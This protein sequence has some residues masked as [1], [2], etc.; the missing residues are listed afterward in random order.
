VTTNEIS[1]D[2]STMGAIRYL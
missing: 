1:K 2:K